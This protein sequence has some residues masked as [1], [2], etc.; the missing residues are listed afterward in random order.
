MY[1]SVGCC[2]TPAGIA[3]NVIVILQELIN[4]DDDN[5]NNVIII[6]TILSRHKVINSL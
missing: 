6:Y 5:D 1:C 2:I 3:S 4:N